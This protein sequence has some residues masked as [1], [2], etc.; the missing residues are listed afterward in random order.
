MGYTAGFYIE[1]EKDRKRF[2]N[3]ISTEPDLI[4]IITDSV[5]KEFFDKY[6]DVYDIGS[7]GR[8]FIEALEHMSVNDE[9]D[10]DGSFYVKA[11]L[12]RS[13]GKLAKELK[14]TDAVQAALAAGRIGDEEQ[15]YSIVSDWLAGNVKHGTCTV[16]LPVATSI[17]CDNIVAILDKSKQYFHADTLG[18]VIKR[19]NVAEN[20]K[21]DGDRD[22]NSTGYHTNKEVLLDTKPTLNV[23]GP[24]LNITL[25]DNDSI[26]EWTV[27]D[28][29]KQRSA[30]LAVANA[31][32]KSNIPY[33][34]YE[35]SMRF[36]IEETDVAIN[37]FDMIGAIG[38]VCK[39][40]GIKKVKVSAGW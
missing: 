35:D 17:D 36:I 40:A 2:L 23:N 32:D 22:I 39:K 3:N 12:L 18:E 34:L 38:R 10:E 14:K 21:V 30:Y 1:K 8:D 15:S 5:D 29:V 19:N 33:T 25:S 24:K 20:V 7:L 37:M 13:L 28:P 9:Q 31:M 4:H 26:I 11:S 27:S 16:Q 6:G